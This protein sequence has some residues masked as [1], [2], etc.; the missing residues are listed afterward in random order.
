MSLYSLPTYHSPLLTFSSSFPS[1]P[2]YVIFSFF[3]SNS[4]FPLTLFSFSK[5]SLVQHFFFIQSFKA[6]LLESFGCHIWQM[7]LNFES[8]LIQNLALSTIVWHQV[9]VWIGL[10]NCFL[11]Q[12]KGIQWIY[13]TK[14]FRIDRVLKP[15]GRKKFEVPDKKAVLFYRK[16]LLFCQVPQFFLALLILKRL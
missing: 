8:Q 1:T 5:R 15:Q 13:L 3:T 16:R 10:L 12:Q 11:P 14:C 7:V 2:F 9:D 6:G 4:S